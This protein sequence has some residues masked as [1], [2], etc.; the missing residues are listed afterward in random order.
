MDGLPR[1]HKKTRTDCTADGDK[2]QVAVLQI[3]L[4]FAAMSV[5]VFHNRLPVTQNI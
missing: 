5:L 4:Q 3:A 2:L 1:T